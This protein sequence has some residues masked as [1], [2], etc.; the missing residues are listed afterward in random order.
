VPDVLASLDLMRS[1]QL[2]QERER[3]TQSICSRNT[4]TLLLAELANVVNSAH[5]SS[6]QQLCESFQWSE[7]ESEDKK[8]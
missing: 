4:Y 2:S 6:K 5:T 3:D 1:L 7:G 8:Q